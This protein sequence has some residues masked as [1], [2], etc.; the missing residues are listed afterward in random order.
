MSLLISGFD[1]GQGDNSENE[2]WNR[3]TICRLLGDFAR[4]TGEPI[5]L[6]VGVLTV[7]FS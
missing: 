1:Y 2:I 7:E 5:Y 6:S 3:E 4:S